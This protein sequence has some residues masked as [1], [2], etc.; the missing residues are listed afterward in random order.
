MLTN[1]KMPLDILQGEA[2]KSAGEDMQTSIFAVAK[3]FSDFMASTLGPQSLHKMIVEQDRW[4]YIVTSDGET[5]LQ[6]FDLMQFKAKHPVARLMVELSKAQ[7]YDLG[8]GTT[9]TVVLAGHLL[10]E[11][12]K[13]VLMGLHPNT[14]AQGYKVA[15]KQALV[16]AKELASPTTRDNLLRVA[17]TALDTKYTSVSKEQLS[18]MVVEAIMRVSNDGKERADPKDVHLVRRKG[19]GV[20]HS[21]LYHGFIVEKK[22]L[23]DS[24]PERMENAK[25]AV[26]DVPLTVKRYAGIFGDNPL[27]EVEIKDVDGLKAHREEEKA[28]LMD[29]FVKLRDVGADCVISRKLIDHRIG[30]WMAKEGIIGIQA[31]PTKDD[32]KRLSKAVGARIISDL[33]TIREEDLGFADSIEEKR[34]PDKETLI[35]IRNK[36]AN[37]VT[38]LLR[39]GAHH[40]ISEVERGMKDAIHATSNA[41]NGGWI[42]PAGG[43]CE[44]AIAERLRRYALTLSDKRQLAVQAFADALEGIPRTLITNSGMDQVKI[45]MDLRRTQREKGPSYGFDANIRE[46][47]DMMEAGI[48]EPLSLKESVYKGAFETA[49]TLLRSESVIYGRVFESRI[50]NEL[51]KKRER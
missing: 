12:E 51:R 45:L 4:A 13:L 14:I 33:E 50:K 29:M 32:L 34:Y 11:A 25:V 43:A 35:F 27:H 26:I 6:R 44:V 24:M 39:G 28:I 49:D 8:D 9:S 40:V 47:R 21:T 41:L 2:E 46:I 5:I 1:P 37:T 42:L 16:Y 7:D 10:K 17:M 48:I 19:T 22:M 30:R 23:D 36:H 20:L 31:I 38:I 3:E 15:L 18:K